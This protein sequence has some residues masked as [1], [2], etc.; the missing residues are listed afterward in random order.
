MRFGSLA[1]AAV[2]PP[3]LLQ[4]C[5]TAPAQQTAYSQQCEDF[6]HSGGYPYL[7][8]GPVYGPNSSIEQLPG[9]PPLIHRPFDPD[10]QRQLDEEDYLRNWCQHNMAGASR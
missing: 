2:I 7:T 10:F 9:A 5:G 3:L 6:A 1:L 4:A 8:G